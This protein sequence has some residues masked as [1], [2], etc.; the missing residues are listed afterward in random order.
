MPVS[1]KDKEDGEPGGGP[2]SFLSTSRWENQSRDNTSQQGGKMQSTYVL[3][4]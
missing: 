1:W 3:K 2:L 4:R